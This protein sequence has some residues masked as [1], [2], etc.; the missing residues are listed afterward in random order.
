MNAPCRR[1]VRDLSVRLLSCLLLTGALSVRFHTFAAATFVRLVEADVVATSNSVSS[2]SFSAA[3]TTGNLIV[4]RVFYN[5]T[6]QAVSSITDT[7]NNSYAKAVGPTTGTGALAGWR[8]ELWYARN[9]IGGSG[10]NVTA[11]FD[12]I[13]NGEKAITAHEYAGLDTVAPLDVTAAQTGSG[14]NAS[15][16]TGTTTTASEMI[17]GAALMGTCG[18]PGSGFA[19]RSSLGCNV[20][21][22]RIVTTTGSYAAVVANTAQSTIVQMATFRAAGQ[23]PPDTTPPSVPTGLSATVVSQS[24]ITVSWSASTDNV[25]TTGYQVFRDGGQVGTATGTSFSSTDL[26]AST[27]YTYAVKAVDAAG[28]VS[29]LSTSVTA[30]TLAATSDTTPPSVPTGLTALALTQSQIDLSWRPSTDNVGVVGYQVFRAGTQVG[31]T[32]GVAY[33]DAGLTASTAYSY[34]VAAYDAAGNTSAV[35]ASASAV[36]LAQGSTISYTTAFPLTENPIAEGGRWINGGTVGL[37]WTNVSTTPGLAIGL[38]SGFNGYDDPT[39][40][41]TGT[42]GPD[43]TAEATVFTTHQNASIFEEVEL[44]LRTT[45]APHRIT[46]YEILFSARSGAS[47]YTQIVRWN[48]ALGNWTELDGRGGQ[49]YGIKTG[50]VVKATIVGNVITSYINGVEVLQVTDSTYTSGSPGIGFYLEGATGVN[51]DYGF[52]SFTAVSNAP[53]DTQSPSVPTGLLAAVISQSQINLSWQPSTDNVATTGYQIFRSGSQIGSVSGTSFSDTGLAAGTSYTYGVRAV[54]AAGNVS[55]LSASVSATTPFADMTPPSV[56]TNVTAAAQSSSAVGLSWSPSSDNIGVVG[57]K[58]YRGTTQVGTVTGTS[59][60]DTGLDPSTTYSYQVAAYDAANNVSATSAAVIATTSSVSTTTGTVHAASCSQADVQNAI[61]AANE[62]DTV[63]VPAGVCTWTT[64]A[65]DTAAV[66]VSTK[67][68]TLQGAGIDQTVIT[69]P[70]STTPHEGALRIDGVDGKSYR[71]SGFTF[72]G[73]AGPA[74]M[75]TVS[76]TSKAFRVDH[77][78]F[79]STTGL[80]TGI[81]VAGATYGVLDHNTF[82]NT[83]IDIEDDGDGSWMRPLNLGGSGR[84]LRGGQHLRLQPGRVDRG[85]PPRR[86]PR[87]PV[88]HHQRG[89]RDREHLCLGLPW[90]AKGRDLCQY[91]RR[92]RCRWLCAEHA[93][94]PEIGD[95]RDLQ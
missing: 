33:S 60:S 12:G 26:A 76:G 41:L 34:T 58:V 45:I 11:T 53:P 1:R 82:A 91:A 32:T 17:F 18:S 25:A 31:T 22:D 38:E 51:S 27:S 68:L 28:N 64:P 55:A 9:V 89:R 49:Q 87:V 35:S 61:T 92:H 3:V 21:E 95:R 2:G 20:S 90:H 80:E 54:D 94:R 67:A 5:S 36:T 59:F 66:A 77:N 13:F 75:L 56:P 19:G 52:T 81:H 84:G 86:P 15:S 63:I 79:V 62:A 43:Q 14:A 40:I 23:T 30:T 71:V 88:Q 24:Q 48:G 16:G 70:T 29:A 44:R 65:P 78:K 47:A 93:L 73:G 10:L 42:W 4:V 37:D 8:Q 72:S 57:Y 46:G 6:S 85:G 39:A 7:K 50:D 83:A 69:T 74:D